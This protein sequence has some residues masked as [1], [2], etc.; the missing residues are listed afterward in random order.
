M[1]FMNEK[2][3]AKLGY[4]N[5]F[6]SNVRNNTNGK[7]VLVIHDFV[8]AC[9]MAKNNEVYYITDDEERK[10][11]FVRGVINNKEFGKDD[12]VELIEDWKNIDKFIE[13]KFGK[14]MKFDLIIGNPPYE[15]NGL[16]YLKILKAVKTFSI[17]ENVIWLCPSN[18]C[19]TVYHEYGN[20]AEEVK[21][22]KIKNNIDIG[23]PFEG[24][25]IENVSIFH[26][27]INGTKTLEN[28]WLRW[29]SNSKQV[30]NIFD[31]FENYNTHIYDKGI[32]RT[33][34]NNYS[35]YCGTSEFA[36]RNRKS[37]K[38]VSMFEDP[39]I[40]SNKIEKS[41]YPWWN[42]KTKNECENFIKYC[43]S[44]IAKFA[45]F[46]LKYNG[47]KRKNLKLIPYLNDYTHPW[48]DKEI[49]KEL[50]LTKEEYNYICEEMKPYV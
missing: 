40:I 19:D 1:A 50:G 38:W 6:W 45:W 17:D 14:D 7:K 25:S 2:S 15:G 20:L 43:K 29:Y 31:K 4:Q 16:L 48:T 8:T 33:N 26:F 3:T 30:K 24:V 11:T 13:E 9:I 44:P 23:N 18:F 39:I 12:R 37:N 41:W 35:W 36:E 10:N 47:Y 34:H 27:N 22:Y 5:E 42:F 32:I 49:C 21:K 46:L 28:A